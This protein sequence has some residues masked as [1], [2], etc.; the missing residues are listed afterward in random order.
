MTW[1]PNRGSTV[2]RVQDD[3]LSS[4]FPLRS[5]LIEE[6]SNYLSLHLVNKYWQEKVH[7][8][9]VTTCILIHAGG[10][11]RRK[12]ASTVAQNYDQLDWYL[13]QCQDYFNRTIASSE[14]WLG[15]L[16]YA[17]NCPDK[18]ISFGYPTFLM[19]FFDSSDSLHR[20]ILHAAESDNTRE[21]FNTRIV[22]VKLTQSVCLPFYLST[23]SLII[24]HRICTSWLG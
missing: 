5:Y 15:L 2:K 18:I 3:A 7:K 1:N 8:Q 24:H 16:R 6:Q 12:T 20:S 21:R 4:P 9:L 10:E 19:N 14:I 22:I 17:A 11:S 13:A 23:V